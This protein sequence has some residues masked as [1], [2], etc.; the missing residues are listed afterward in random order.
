MS[1]FCENCEQKIYP[2]SETHQPFLL[3]GQQTHDCVGYLKT[4]LRQNDKKLLRIQDPQNQSVQ[5]D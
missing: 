2:N 1:V 4:L 3:N 5:N